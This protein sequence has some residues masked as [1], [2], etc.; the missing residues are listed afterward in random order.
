M[1]PEILLQSD[2]FSE[3]E[4]TDTKSIISKYFDV[5]DIGDDWPLRYND[6]EIK[7]GKGF[8]YISPIRTSLG[9]A[10]RWYGERYFEYANALKWAP[11][12]R[13]H[14]VDPNF[15]FNSADWILNNAYWVSSWPRPYLFIRPVSPFKEFSGNVYSEQ[16]FRNEYDFYTKNKNGDPHLICMYSEAESI[17]TEWRCIFMGGRY[18]SGSQYMSNGELNIKSEVPEDVITFAKELA[19]KTYFYNNFQFV[20]DIGVV[21]GR[22]SLIEVNA[23]ETA[24]FYGADLDKIYETWSKSIL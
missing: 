9:F 4:T 20:L 7:Y 18:I 2:L 5:V 23:F 17:D 14:M 19:V 10:R 6:I 8:R 21:D 1:K 22:L 13:E 24:S 3:D 12:F 16:K 11:Y 15:S